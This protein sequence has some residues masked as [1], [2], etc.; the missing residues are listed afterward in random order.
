MSGTRAV[1][2]VDDATAVAVDL[3][4]A[5]EAFEVYIHRLRRRDRDADQF[6]QVVTLCMCVYIL[7]IT[8]K[9]PMWY[10]KS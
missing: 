1:L 2:R 5:C 4:F 8:Q 7:L 3:A 10:T 9:L 6:V